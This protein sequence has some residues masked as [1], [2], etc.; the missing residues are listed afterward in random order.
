M[1]R[2]TGAILIEIRP[3]SMIVSAWRGVARAASK[4]KRAM[5][6]RG[7]MCD[8]HSIAQQ[9]SP[10]ESGKF[11]FPTVQRPSPPHVD[12][13]DQ[14]QHDEDDRL[15]QRERAERVEL[16]RDGIQQ[17][18]LDVEQDEEHRDEVEADPEAE[19]LAHL[20]RQPAL[21]RVA[22]RALRA[23]A[24]EV[25]PEQRVDGREDQPEDRA[26]A[27]ED[28]RREIGTDHPARICTTACAEM[29]LSDIRHQRASH[30]HSEARTPRR[31]TTSA[32]A[33]I[34]PTSRRTIARTSRRWS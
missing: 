6:S 7:P 33:A 28:E 4:P 11:A 10:K 29:L 20:G 9:A 22:L 1:R 31:A 25:L 3:E 34:T 14:Q 13:G 18:R 12:V 24:G 23:V 17:D 5:S 8:I 27:Q 2:I 30:S 32:E 26:D 16:E 21:V 19:V 15:D